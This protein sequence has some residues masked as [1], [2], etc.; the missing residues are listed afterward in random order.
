MADEH[1]LRVLVVDDH[2]T[3]LDM[4]RQM[5]E[6]LGHAPITA[7]CVA[8][9]AAVDAADYDLLLCD[10]RLPDGEAPDLRRL[11]LERGV[12]VPMV[13]LTAFDTYSL[14]KDQTDGF[15]HVLTKPLDMQDL[16]KLLRQ[17]AIESSH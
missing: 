1:S 5:V 2:P 10:Y 7:T 4:M 11:L 13:L 12:Q 14:S 17:F 6:L 15:S 16:R 9:A 8:E 3:M